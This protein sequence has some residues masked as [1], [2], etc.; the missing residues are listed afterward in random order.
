MNEDLSDDEHPADLNSLGPKVLKTV[1][2][3][4]SRRNAPS[5]A[6]ESPPSCSHW[7]SSDEEPLSKYARGDFRKVKQK[8]AETNYSWS[9]S[10][11]SFNMVVNCIPPSEAV[12]TCKTPLDFLKLFFTDE[13]HHF[14]EQSN[15]NTGC[16]RNKG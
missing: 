1:C 13:L 16:L 7:D 4:E 2:E 6:E 11:P 10:K 3:V 14:I 15:I 9:H 12:K 8:K 5:T